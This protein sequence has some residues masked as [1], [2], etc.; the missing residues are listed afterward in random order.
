M[1]E[2]DGRHIPDMPTADTEGLLPAQV[3][4]RRWIVITA[5]AITGRP[6]T[7]ARV[8]CLSVVSETR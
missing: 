8:F 5:G 4:R 2:N 7:R 1:V 3:P 6:S